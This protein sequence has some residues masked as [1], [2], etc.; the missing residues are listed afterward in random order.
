MSEKRIRCRKTKEKTKHEEKGRTRRQD[1]EKGHGECGRR[2]SV[3]EDTSAP[4]R[5][6]GSAC[7]DWM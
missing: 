4:A 1:R 3:W 6:A 7:G 5:E 2:N